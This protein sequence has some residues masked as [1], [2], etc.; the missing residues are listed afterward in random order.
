MKRRKSFVLLAS[1][2]I[3]LLILF[4]LILLEATGC[5]GCNARELEPF[6]WVILVII[7]SA[8]GGPGGIVIAAAIIIASI[9]SEQLLL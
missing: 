7:G 3:S 1:H 5:N 4:G 8:L 9:L 2:F 6:L